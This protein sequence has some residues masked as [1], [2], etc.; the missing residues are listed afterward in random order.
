MLLKKKKKNTPNNQI[1][2]IK[3]SS[4][5]TIAEMPSDGKIQFKILIDFLLYAKSIYTALHRC[6]LQE[7]ALESSLALADY[8][9]QPCHGL[10]NKMEVMTY[11]CDG[12]PMARMKP[13]QWASECCH[14]SALAC[15]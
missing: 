5:E 3:N 9:K 10:G 8:I 1:S 6:I 2:I 11:Y 7:V 4:A 12:K 13:Y 15:I 14:S